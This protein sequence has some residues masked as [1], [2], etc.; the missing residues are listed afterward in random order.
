MRFDA[1]LF[2]LYGTLVDIHTDEEK[3]SFWRKLA[4]YCSEKGAQY[5]GGQLKEGFH[6]ESEKLF[7]ESKAA[8]PE[9]DL[10]MVF[11]ELYRKKGIVPDGK[12]IAE[13]AWFFRRSS[14]THLRLYAGARELLIHLRKRG[15]V[16]L[17]SNA[18]ALFTG[19]ELDHLGIRNLF[20]AVYLS[21]DYGCRKPD[22][23][24]FTVPFQRDPGLI[25]ERCVMIG[26]D[27]SCD[28]DGAKRAGMRAFYIRSALSPKGD[29]SDNAD[30]SLDGM[31]L[32][33]VRR[34]LTAD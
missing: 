22:P 4:A 24:F 12:T 6:A 7:H 25:P 29:T 26:N 13:T 16:I 1:Y 18:Q 15:K 34:I 32:D 33:R 3:S 17:L 30:W 14:M 31:D 21:S 9:I 10:G 20:D 2:D 19:P 11:L 8:F 27:V 5:D 23:A 28:I